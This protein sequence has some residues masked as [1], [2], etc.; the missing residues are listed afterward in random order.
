MNRLARKVAL[1]FSRRRFRRELEEEMAFHRAQLEEELVAGGSSR[2]AAREQANRQFGNATRLREQSHEAIGLRV[3]TV[4]QD[5]RFAL[6]QLR[7]NPGFAVTAI[8]IL[9]LGMGVSVAIFGFVD[10]AMIRPLP[11]WQPNRLMDVA[12]TA[13]AW[14]RANLSLEDYKDY[15]RL[16]KSFSSLDVYTEMG[17][18]LETHSGVEPVSA[19]RVSDGFFSTLGVKP[20]LGRGFLPG[21]D[22]PG[23]PKIVILSYGAWRTRFGGNRGIV[24]QVVNLSGVAYTVVGVLPREYAFAP[25]G[26]A[27]LWVPLLD[28]AWCEQ[29]RSC[30]NLYGV[31]RLRQGITPQAALAD[32]KAIARRLEAEYPD[33]NRDQ[34]AAV[35][36]LSELILHDIRPVLELLLA[37]AGL[38]L[39]IACI[40]VASL[41][42]VRS[43]SRRR[44]IA[45]RVALGAT[46]VRLTR[47]FVTEGLLLA[48]A[49][50]AGGVS[51][52]CWLMALLTHMVPKAMA[53]GLPFLAAVGLNRDTALFAVAVA[54]GAALLLAATPTL[55]LSLQPIRDG[56][57][58]GGRGHAG[59]LWRRMG[60]NLVVAELA[61]A[62][63]LLVGA[64]LL[65]Q[66]FYRLLHVQL[67]FDP[68]HL[69]A[70]DLLLPDH[71]YPKD[72]QQIAA[73]REV[74]DKISSQ[75]GVVSA[76][77]TSV[78]PVQCNCNTDWIRIAGKP[79]NGEHNEVNEREV[80]PGYL[81]TLRAQLIRGRMLTDD[82]RA[83]KPNV[84]V[85]NEALARKYFPGED[86]LGKTIGDGKLSPDSLRQVVGVVRDVHESELDT[87]VWPTEYEPLYQNADIFTT[88][89]VRTRQ[90]PG[91]YLPTLV[92]TLHV[93][94]PNLGVSNEETMEQ[95]IGETQSALLH[96]F[97]AWLVGCFA[98]M[99]LILGVVGLYGVIA[100]SVSRRTRE[101]GVRMALGAQRSAVYAL[102]MR[103]A[104][105]LTATGIGIGLVCSVDASLLIRKLLFG[106]A[107]WD[108]PTFACVA[109]VL[110]GAAMAASFLPAYRAAGVN[111]TEALRAE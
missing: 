25:L 13:R 35:Q 22:Q 36:P 41:L 49:G 9:A 58:E 21:E 31:G 85:I 102:V 107:A 89:V 109:L 55:R 8:L 23:K 42:L 105:R 67:G 86:P 81:A 65:G 10:A 14:P 68:G 80:S 66:S 97:S 64:G 50:C 37:G 26:D 70:L 38:L 6:R 93:L 54:L 103:Q 101:I 4:A 59:M 63:V 88:L 62:V 48:A 61:V 74:L 47:Q 18:L 20:M 106:V 43:E 51:A 73:F 52:A 90:A 27:E 44:E 46:P 87:E 82:D 1:L 111:P 92:K 3:E 7:H 71:V 94:N 39:L 72:A 96:R 104:G 11:Y 34:G 69:A 108:A 12:E 5:L 77:L 40:N 30:H 95:R 28:P 99:A 29:R 17:Y 57:Q 78:L 79:Y 84:I 16:N 75:P 19:A 60:A 24:G 15:K 33:S 91:A 83:G 32:M 110:A 2:E 98:A 53:D 100:Y 45:V 56:L 76:G